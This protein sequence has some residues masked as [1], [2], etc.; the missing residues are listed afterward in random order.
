MLLLLCC[1]CCCCCCC[2][3]YYYYYYVFLVLQPSSLACPPHP[4]QPRFAPPLSF[5]DVRTH[6]DDTDSYNPMATLFIVFEGADQIQSYDPDSVLCFARCTHAFLDLLDATN[7]GAAH[8]TLFRS[9]GMFSFSSS[10]VSY[11]VVIVL[12][13]YFLV[14]LVLS[15]DDPTIRSHCNRITIYF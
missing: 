5:S 2:Y 15:L 9:A 10:F 8:Y 6:F 14:I 12:L 1:C 11:F 4:R 13:M 3:Y 7:S